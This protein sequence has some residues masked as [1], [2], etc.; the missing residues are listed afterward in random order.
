[1]ILAI[2]SFTELYQRLKTALKQGDLK[3]FVDPNVGGKHANV[4]K[5]P[6]LKQLQEFLLPFLTSCAKFVTDR[7]EGMSVHYHPYVF[8]LLT[9]R[10]IFL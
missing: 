3:P 4:K 8:R 2:G 9:L 1:M 7:S 5:F 6:T 10:C